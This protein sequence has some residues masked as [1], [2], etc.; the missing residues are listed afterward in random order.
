[1]CL[2]ARFPGSARLRPSTALRPLDN[3]G[4]PPSE[5]AQPFST[6]LSRRTT[7]ISQPDTGLRRTKGRVQRTCRIK[8][9]HDVPQVQQLS[10]VE[11][12]QFTVP[13]KMISPQ[14]ASLSAFVV[15]AMLHATPARAVC[16][17]GQLAVG[18]EFVQ[19][20]GPSSQLAHSASQ[21]SQPG[22]SSPAPATPSTSSPA[23]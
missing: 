16:A 6:V 21:H 19:E 18:T 7:I 13:P 1:M 8:G 14:L 5:T 10:T 22:C 12:P 2:R 3:D 17:S 15:A 23:S 4:S 9:V 20:V 11:H